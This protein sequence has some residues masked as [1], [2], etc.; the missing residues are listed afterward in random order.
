MSYFIIDIAYP[1]ALSIYRKREHSDPKGA[2]PCVNPYNGVSPPQ[3]K[4]CCDCYRTLQSNMSRVVFV[5]TN[6]VGRKHRLRQGCS[7]PQSPS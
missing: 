2:L 4:A 1:T 5:K 3:N 7:R 6:K